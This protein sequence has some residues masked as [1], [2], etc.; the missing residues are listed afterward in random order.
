[1]SKSGY[2]SIKRILVGMD[3][4]EDALNALQLAVKI[5]KADKSELI[6]FHVKELPV[7]LDSNGEIQVE[8]G[9]EEEE[10]T[11]RIGKALEDA[12]QFAKKAGTPARKV[13]SEHKK[14]VGQ[15]IADY[16]Q[17]Q[18]VSLIVVGSRGMGAIKR[19]LVGSVA[20]ELAQ[21][22]LCSVLLVR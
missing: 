17:A 1:M 21:H 6:L 9:E 15:T 12:A 5:S 4:S 16:A 14:S 8:S 18:D 13:V 20:N 11:R 3:A 10:E 19:K 2:K 7:G 22:A